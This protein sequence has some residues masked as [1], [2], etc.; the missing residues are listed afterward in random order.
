M[1]GYHGDPERT[2]EAMAGGYYH[3]GDVGH[4]ATP[5]GYITYV[6]RA[7]DVFKACDYRIS[8]F[9]LESVLIEHPAVAEAA[10][11]PAP[12]P[13]RLAV[14]KAYVVLAAGARADRRDRRVDPA[15]LPGEPGAVQADPPAG[16]RRAAQDDLRQDPPGRAAPARGR[17]R[18]RSGGPGAR[19]VPRRGLRRP[20]GPVV[21]ADA[22]PG[23]PGRRAGHRL[24][25]RRRRCSP[26]R[27][28][29]SAT[30]CAAFVDERVI[31]VASGYWERAEFPLELVAPV[32]RA[33]GGR[34]LDH[35]VRLPG[36]EPRWP[37]AWSPCELARGD[38]SFATFNSVHSGLVMAAVALL[39][40]VEQKQRWLP[41]LAGCVK[42][43]AFA[44][45][46]PDHG[47]DVVR[48]GTRARRDGAH[49]V[50]DG[51]K[52]WIGNGTLADVVIV[53]AR[54]DDGD[55]GAF[56]VDRRDDDATGYQASVITGKTSNRGLWQADIRLDGVRIPLDNRLAGARTFADTGRC[57]TKSRQSIAWEGLGH[58]I[59]AYECALA[60]AKRREQFGRPIAGFQL[61]Q[62]KLSHML[63]D[64][65]GMQLT[66]LRL[67]QLQAAG[68]VRLEHAALAK[69]QTAAGGPAGVRDGPGHPGRQRDPAGEPRGPA[70]RRHGG[71]L[72]LRGHRHRAVVDRRPGHHRARRLRWSPEPTSP[73]LGRFRSAA[74]DDAPVVHARFDDLRADTAIGFAEPERVL[75]ADRSDQVVGVLDEVQRAVEAGRWA[76]GYLAYEAA[77]GL[78]PG[79]AVHPACRRHAAG[80]VRHRRPAAP[81]LPARRGEPAEPGRLHR[82]H[83]RRTGRRPSTSGRSR[84]V[85]ARIADGDTYQCNL[86][87]RMRGPVEGDAARLYRDLALT[88]RGSYNAYLDLGRCVIASASPELFFELPRR[89]HPAAP[90]EGHRA[91]RPRPGRG[92][93]PDRRAALQQQGA[94]REHHDRRSDAQRRVAGRRDR[95]RSGCRRCS[96]SSGS[97]R[98]CS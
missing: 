86:T 91:A 49:W 61:V 66:C 87:V 4:A 97:R 64:I 13:L 41:D 38:G 96:R 34:R 47:S 69:L 65:T 72:H 63:A 14:P 2:A 95:Q 68:R 5:T 43:G 71:G 67:A 53:W 81:G 37:R 9:E 79:L 56:V 58:A 26:T 31:P 27:S 30:G 8:P 40:S 94:R 75:V 42:L 45:T 57:L 85:R 33:R 59:G 11:V 16:V 70:P 7:D 54:D 88:Q 50:L 29:R 52:R 76:F 90:D 60:Y 17:A 21:T 20:A 80:L 35:R 82:A 22:A 62:D 48:L 55:V 92:P 46:E 89:R 73:G 23:R 10:V 18:L 3:T 12:D 36:D 19:R 25:R 84:A 98:S 93:R 28:G 24:L 77:A 1:V 74:R 83:G 44:L 51:A 15:A 39:G 32:R 6:G 78:D